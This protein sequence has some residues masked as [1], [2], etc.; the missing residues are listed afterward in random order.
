M[1]ATVSLV[2]LMSPAAM[3]PDVWSA[4]A[5]CVGGACASVAP[6]PVSLFTPR[7]HRLASRSAERGVRL[8]AG[9]ASALMITFNP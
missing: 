2:R 1:N 5:R 8:R 4:S 6:G 7:A 9:Q 3:R